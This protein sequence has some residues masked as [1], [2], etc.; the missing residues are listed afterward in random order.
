MGTSAISVSFHKSSIV[1]MWGG[2]L[3]TLVIY[4]FVRACHF[5]RFGCRVFNLARIIQK[6]DFFLLK[7]VVNF[8]QQTTPAPPEKV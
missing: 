5:L 6:E 2:K 7:E 3:K 8:L 4:T 1:T